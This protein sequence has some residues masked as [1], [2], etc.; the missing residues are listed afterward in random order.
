MV[1]LKKKVKNCFCR[2]KST[3]RGFKVRRLHNDF[4]ARFWGRG[5]NRTTVA[6]TGAY[7]H[8]NTHEKGGT[9]A[10]TRHADA[11]SVHWCKSNGQV[12]AH[13]FSLSLRRSVLSSAPDS[14]LCVV[15]LG[16]TNMV[17]FFY[18]GLRSQEGVGAMRDHDSKDVGNT[19]MPLPSWSSSWAQ[20]RSNP[21][22]SSAD[23]L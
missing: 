20:M 7:T 15:S 1:P 21:V 3:R 14:S 11:K 9:P 6:G 10:E 8:T 13:L 17:W 4:L 12:W 23:A 5:K 22:I 19:G 18:H 2:V 16:S